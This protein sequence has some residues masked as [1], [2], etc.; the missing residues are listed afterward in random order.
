MWWNHADV[1]INKE[2]AG[3]R[4]WLAKVI[5]EGTTQPGDAVTVVRAERTEAGSRPTHGAYGSSSVSHWARRVGGGTL[6]TSFSS[7]R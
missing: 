3:G 4:G 2:R 6:R 5:V 7:F 1:P